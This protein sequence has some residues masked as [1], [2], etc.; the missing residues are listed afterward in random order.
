MSTDERPETPQQRKTQPRNG[1]RVVVQSF[2]RLMGG[3]TR[4]DLL[5]ACK[6]AVDSY[7][8]GQN[9]ADSVDVKS[10]HYDKFGRAL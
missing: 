2:V 10:W 7:K 1:F 9:G 4:D 6:V 8:A 5:D 3:Y